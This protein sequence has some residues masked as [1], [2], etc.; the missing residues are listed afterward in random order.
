M[1]TKKE[2]KSTREN[3]DSKAANEK[4]ISLVKQ[5]GLLSANQK[6]PTK[7]NSFVRFN[8]IDTFMTITSS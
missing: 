4:I 1:R 8:V 3:K 7:P 6:P 2:T 5:S